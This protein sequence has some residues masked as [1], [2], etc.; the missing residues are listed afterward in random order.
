MMFC[1]RCE[2]EL[3]AA[4]AVGVPAP[5]GGVIIP[6]H[7]LPR[8]ATHAHAAGPA[9][10]RSPRVL[11][12]RAAAPPLP[13]PTVAP[14]P[15]ELR[16]FNAPAISDAFAYLI[17]M[18]SETNSEGTATSISSISSSIRLTFSA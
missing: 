5:P 10:R 14:P 17:G 4:P 8:I 11:R 13:P 7:G 6:G 9:H 2:N 15:P 1:S 18:T 12:V 16:L 3:P